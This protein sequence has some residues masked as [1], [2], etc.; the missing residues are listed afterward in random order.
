MKTKRHRPIC[1]PVSDKKVFQSPDEF[2]KWAKKESY[3]ASKEGIKTKTVCPSNLEGWMKTWGASYKRPGTCR[4]LISTNKRLSNNSRSSMKRYIG[5][6]HKRCSTLYK[7]WDTTRISI[8]NKCN[9]DTK[10]HTEKYMKCFGKEEAARE[11]PNKEAKFNKCGTRKCRKEKSIADRAGKQELHF[12][13]R[14][15]NPDGVL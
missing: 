10:N 5:C 13:R 7:K 15:M 11:L 9:K 8:V 12:I 14:Y 2:M 6:T 4:R 3:C 1:V